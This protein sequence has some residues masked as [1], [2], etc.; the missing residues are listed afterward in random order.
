MAYIDAGDVKKIRNALKGR[1][2]PMGFKFSVRKGS[3]SLSVDVDI[4]QSPVKFHLNK[5]AAFRA[6]DGDYHAKKVEQGRHGLNHFHLKNY[7]NSGLL[8]EMLNII[9]M[10]PDRKWYDR[11][12]AM[13]DYFDTA[14]YIHMGVGQWD[15]PCVYVGAAAE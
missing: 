3:G 15:K 13:V 6:H 4:M 2:G 1:F 8:V 7:E 12:D 14:F 5:E 10:A 11:S 9:K